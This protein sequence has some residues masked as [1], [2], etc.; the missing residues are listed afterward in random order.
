MLKRCCC[1]KAE[2]WRL[3][4]RRRCYG[5]P[6][7]TS[8]RKGRRGD[9]VFIRLDR[10]RESV[11]ESR[12]QPEPRLSGRT[13][14][15]EGRR[16]FNALKY[17]RDGVQDYGYFQILKNCDHGAGHL[18][19]PVRWRRTGLTGRAVMHC[20]SL[21]ASRWESNRSPRMFTIAQREKATC[22]HLELLRNAFGR[23]VVHRPIE[24]PGQA[25]YGTLIACHL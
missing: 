23:P 21:C 10:D 12:R 18:N 25:D 22:F 7:S 16:S 24:K 19:S 20:W 14:R 5:R 6:R 8:T 4:S 1:P 2:G 9:A 15:A 11:G 3:P 13:G 17:L